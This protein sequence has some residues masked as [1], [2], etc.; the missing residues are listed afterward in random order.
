[1]PGAGGVLGQ[2]GGACAVTEPGA[3]CGGEEEAA[4]LSQQLGKAGGGGAVSGL[5]DD[6]FLVG[7]DE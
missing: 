2:E 7:G 3:K 4:V 5:R 1:M 6:G